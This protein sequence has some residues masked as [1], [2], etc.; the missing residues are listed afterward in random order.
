M[1]PL[2]SKRETEVLVLAAEGLSSREIAARLFVSK[3][4]C[5]FHMGNAYRK[6]KVSNRIQ[7]INKLRAVNE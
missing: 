6:L 1:K 5:D 4:T 7:A 3:R 2:L